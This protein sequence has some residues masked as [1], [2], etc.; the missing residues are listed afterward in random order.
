MKLRSYQEA[1]VAGV[2]EA[3]KEY[4][5]VLLVLP[6]GTGKTI[7]FAEIIRCIHPRRA[8]VLAHREELIWQ[9]GRS[10]AQL[11]IALR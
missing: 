11:L 6:T 5:S 9:A 2:F 7:C 4:Q 10:I 8:L 3:W 1:A